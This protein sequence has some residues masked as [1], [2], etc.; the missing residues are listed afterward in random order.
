M[1]N[2][3]NNAHPSPSLLTTAENY[4]GPAV[5]IT[6][7]KDDQD[8]PHDYE[9]RPLS[10]AWRVYYELSPIQNFFI[11]GDSHYLLVEKDTYRILGLRVE[12]SE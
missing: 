6:A 1:E 9:N 10:N 12:R 3:H 11:G 2:K 8:G 7:I 4:L 5:V